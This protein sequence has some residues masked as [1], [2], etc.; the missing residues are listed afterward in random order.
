MTNNELSQLPTLVLQSLLQTA[1]SMLRPEAVNVTDREAVA[2]Q[3]CA[4]V[5]ELGRRNAPLQP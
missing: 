2:Q 4:L 3:Q 1:N 5:A